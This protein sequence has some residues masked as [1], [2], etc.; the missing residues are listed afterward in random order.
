MSLN[1]EEMAI[2][3]MLSA[4]WIRIR[5]SSSQ[6]RLFLKPLSHRRF[7]SWSIFFSQILS[8]FMRDGIC[9]FSDNTGKKYSW[10]KASRVLGKRNCSPKVI[11]I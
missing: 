2:S 6:P 1:T 7:R 9:L 3:V 11:Q 4:V 8:P 10:Y 5:H